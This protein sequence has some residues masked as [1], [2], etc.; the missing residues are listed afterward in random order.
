M[1]KVM[2]T[3]AVADVEITN[4]HDDEERPIV[5][6][7][8]NHRGTGPCGQGTRAS[9]YDDAINWAEGHADMGARF[10]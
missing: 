5:L 7:C 1:A 4:D 10:A 3:G 8:V 6:T 9:S 2:V